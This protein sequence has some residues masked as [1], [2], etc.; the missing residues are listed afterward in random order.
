MA[1]SRREPYTLTRPKL[2]PAQKKPKKTTK[3]VVAAAMK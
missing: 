1:I 3:K 2:S